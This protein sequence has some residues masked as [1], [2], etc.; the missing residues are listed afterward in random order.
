MGGEYQVPI[1]HAD[2]IPNFRALTHTVYNPNTEKSVVSNYFLFDEY[3]STPLNDR[4]IS[5][6]YI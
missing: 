3:F 5:V 2:D 6:C 4:V 1:V